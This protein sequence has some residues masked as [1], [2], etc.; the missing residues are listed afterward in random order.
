VKLLLQ[1]SKGSAQYV[2]GVKGFLEF[3]FKDKHE[4]SKIYCPCQSCVHTTVQPSN[5]MFE[6]LVCNGILENYDQWDFMEIFLGMEIIIWLKIVVVMK[7][8]LI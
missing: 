1:C 3:A 2:A 7:D 4:G 6:H 8:K 5:V